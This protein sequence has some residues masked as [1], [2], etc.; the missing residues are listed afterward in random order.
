MQ[1]QRK[2]AEVKETRCEPCFH[3]KHNKLTV[4]AHFHPEPSPELALQLVLWSKLQVGYQISTGRLWL[5]RNHRQEG[6]PPSW[7]RL[8][9]GACQCQ[10]DYRW[11]RNAIAGMRGYSASES[12]AL[13]RARGEVT[14][15]MCAKMARLQQDLEKRAIAHFL[16]KNRL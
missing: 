11:L 8:I 7:L 15:R 6:I 13:Q 1:C 10:T 2:L 3:W 16:I 9:V 5:K 4:S 12:G 14:W